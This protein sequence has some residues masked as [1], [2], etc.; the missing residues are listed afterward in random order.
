MLSA[1]M[2]PNSIDAEQSLLG[3]A[4]VDKNAVVDIVQ[5]LEEKDFYSLENQAIFK[6]IIELNGSGKVID[7]IT[8]SEKLKYMGQ[9]ELIGGIEHLSNLVSDVVTTTNLKSCISIVKGKSVRRKFIRAATNVIE[10]AYDGEY[11]TITDFKADVMKR[12]DISVKEKTNDTIQDITLTVMKNIEERYNNKT[13]KMPYGI[14][15]LDKYTGGAHETDMTV[16]AARPSVGKTSFV[17]QCGKYFAA[18]GNSVA[19][20][21]LEMGKDQLVERMIAND[22][23]IQLDKLRNPVLMDGQDQL[24][25]SKTV[26]RINELNLHIVDDIF[27]IETIRA[28]CVELKTK[29]KLNAVII[30]YLQLCDSTQRFKSKEERVSYISRQTKLM[31][32]ELR[33]PVIILSQLNRASEH[34]NR[35]PQLIDLR[36]SGAIE[37]DADSVLFLHD[38]EYGKLQEDATKT[39]FDIDLIIAKQRNGRRDISTSIKFYKSTQRWED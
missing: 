33:V 15:W 32:K 30:D 8:V 22:G 34:D 2:P 24:K 20:F 39:V 3:A 18:K 29:E 11:E 4:M 35:R 13:L 27:K 17:M 12:M 25:L 7:I 28:K 36:D 19:I 9:L 14:E 10:S 31:A 5:Q 21:S 38:P 23:L 16:L 37:Q 26:G 6:A 1:R